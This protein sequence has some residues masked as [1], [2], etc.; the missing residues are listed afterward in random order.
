MREVKINGKLV[1]IETGKQPKP[2]GRHAGRAKSDL[3]MLLE[4]MRDGESA[5]LPITSAAFKG[6]SVMMSKLGQLNG[7]RYSYRTEGDG[8]RVYRLAAK[9]Q[10]ALP[11]VRLAAPK[12]NLTKPNGIMSA[13]RQ[14]W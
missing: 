5:F 14:G 7:C 3:R 9:P 8:V 11:E 13:L 10:A 2:F 12:V 1:T 6:K 4:A